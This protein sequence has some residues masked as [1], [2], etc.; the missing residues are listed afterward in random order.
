MTKQPA[1]KALYAKLCDG[2]HWTRCPISGDLHIAETGEHING[3][4]L[5]A[6]H[7]RQLVERDPYLPILGVG[8]GVRQKDAR[9]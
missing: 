1:W 8:G 2:L 6:L 4:S 5:A 9:P 7:R 3:G